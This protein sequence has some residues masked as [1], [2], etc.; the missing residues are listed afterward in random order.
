MKCTF[1]I[2]QKVVF[3]PASVDV[4]SRA[5]LRN[6]ALGFIYP[7]INR[8]YTVREVRLHSISGEPLLLLE[9]IQNGSLADSRGYEREPG[10]EAK[11]FRPVETRKTDISCFTALLTPSKEQVP[12]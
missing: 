6:E 1:V 9:E 12:A 11:H 3:A 8:V 4:G 5:R 10:F 7:D 2:G